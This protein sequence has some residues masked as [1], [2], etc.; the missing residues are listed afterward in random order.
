LLTTVHLAWERW[1]I[2]GEVWGDFLGRLFAV[3]F[4]GTIF[5]PFAL[6]A[7]LFSDPLHLRT[8]P[9]RWLDR[10]PVGTSLDDAR[11]QF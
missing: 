4:Y 7:R 1:K 10:A 9:R 2:I 8:A 11:R 5:V 3:A 6:A